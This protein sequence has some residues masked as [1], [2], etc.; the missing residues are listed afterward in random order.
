MQV[1]ILG[2]RKS[3]SGEITLP[4]NVKS[5]SHSRGG[6][7]GGVGAAKSELHVG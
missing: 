1:P 7:G 5:E 6:G 2:G 4:L 3:K